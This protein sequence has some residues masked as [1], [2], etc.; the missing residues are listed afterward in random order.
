[1]SM[2]S[3]GSSGQ[4][5]SHM[6]GSG[7]SRRATIQGYGKVSR[8]GKFGMNLTFVQLEGKPLVSME[9]N[10]VQKEEE[11]VEV[12]EEMEGILD[13]LFRAIQDKV[14]DVGHRLKRVCFEPSLGYCRSLGSGQRHW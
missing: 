3:S 13:D 9:T 6:Q 7:C 8:W 5:L 12:P 10:Q 14:L 11:E 1:M 2:P 4:K